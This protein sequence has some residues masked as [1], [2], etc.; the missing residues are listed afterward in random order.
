M[1]LARI[2]EMSSGRIVVAKGIVTITFGGR[3]TCLRRSRGL[4]ILAQLL[5]REGDTVHVFE[6]GPHP[7]PAAERT[8]AGALLD[9]KAKD[10]YHTRYIQIVDRL[11]DVQSR[12]DERA[13]AA[14]RC[15][16]DALACE[17]SRAIGLGG[18]DRRFPSPV[19]RARIRVTVAL[20]RA[21]RRIAEEDPLLADHFA[22]RLRT[23]AMCMYKP[24]PTARVPWTVEDKTLRAPRM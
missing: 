13:A 6:L 14:L 4:E 18:R 15:E 3:Q 8:N 22:A 10:A 9:R 5:A 23:G 21:V 12:G 7:C 19:E 20:M 17:L 1:S 16:M 11:E 2:V 24:D